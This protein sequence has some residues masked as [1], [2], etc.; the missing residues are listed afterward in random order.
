MGM[1]S[2]AH[3]ICRAVSIACWPSTMRR[4]AAWS[5]SST[6]I[7]IMSTPTRRSLTPSSARTWAISRAARSGSPELG[8]IAPCRPVLP[9]R[10][11]P[12]S[13]HGHCSRWALAAEP[14]S[15]MWGVPLRV[16]SAQRSA[17]P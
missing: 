5:W 6:G 9:A 2:S 3:L 17:R 14:K 10:E 13:G 4:P 12:S 15:Q 7:S 11:W 1:I 8:A 16:T